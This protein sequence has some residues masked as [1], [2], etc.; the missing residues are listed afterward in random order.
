MFTTSLS[1]RLVDASS[2][3]REIVSQIAIQAQA[4]MEQVRQLSRGLF[5]VEVDA[6][7]LTHALQ[8]L[9]ATTSS[10]GE[11]ECRMEEAGNVLV[12]DNRVA[13]EL[14]RIAQEAVTNALKHAHATS[15]VVRLVAKTG[16]TILSVAD[17]GG[18]VQAQSSENQGM[19]LRIMRYRAQSI[20]ASLTVESTPN[21]TVMTCLLR[22]TPSQST[23]FPTEW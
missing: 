7:G 4:S 5:P 14:Y 19:G 1:K 12:R 18:G 15:I 2:E 20:G 22:D 8:Q 13:T 16:M 23:P 21:G 9:A 6:A 3:V 17:D 11:I 10:L